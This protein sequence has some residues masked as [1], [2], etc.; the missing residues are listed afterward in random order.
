M[1]K[2]FLAFTIILGIFMT[3]CVEKKV[4]PVTPPV[5][6]VTNEKPVISGASD[7]VIAFGQTVD[8]TDGVTAN[9]EEDGDLT[10]S[11]TIDTGNF[12][13]AVPGSYDI[14][15]RVEDSE[16]L[17]AT[18]TITVQVNEEDGPT[19]EDMI[20]E[21]I[22]YYNEHQ[23]FSDDQLNLFLRGGVNQSV[24]SWDLDSESIAKNGLI[25]RP[26]RGEEAITLNYTG[27]FTIGDVTVEEDFTIIIN[28]FDDVVLATSKDVPFTNLTTEYNV[29]DGMLTLYF[30][31]N[32]SVPYVDVQSFFDL[33]DGFIDSEM[34]ITFTEEDDTETIFYQYY[35]EDEDETY[36]LEVII[37]ATN[38]NITTNDMGFYWAYVYSTETNYGRHI[39]YVEHADETYVEGENVVFDLNAYRMDIVQN[40]NGIFLPYYLVNQLFAGSSYYNVYYNYDGLYGIY[41]I[42]DTDSD[43]FIQMHSSSMNDTY[44]PADLVLHNYDMLAFDFD[45]FYG[46]QE[47]YSIDTYYDLLSNKQ[48]DL[49]SVRATT[50]DDGLFNFLYKVIDEPHTSFGYP[51]Y[52]SPEFDK[53]PSISKLADFGTRTNNWYGNLY[54]IDDAIG[55]K[56]GLASGTSWNAYSG[57]RPN[58]WFLDDAKTSV[59]ITLDEFNTADIVESDTYDVTEVNDVLEVSDSSLIVPSITEGTKFF[60]YNSSTDANKIL[61]VIAKGASA[62]FVDD[63]KASLVELGYT[64]VQESSDEE[65]KDNGYYALTL[66]EITYMAQVNYDAEYGVLYISFADETPETYGA[67]WLVIADVMETVKGD[68]AVYMEIVMDKLSEVAPDLENAMLDITWNTGGNVGALYRIIGFITDQPYRVSSMSMDSGSTSTSYVQIVGQPYNADLDWALLTSGVTFSAANAMATMF[69]ENDLGPIYGMTSGGGTASITPVLLPNGTAFTMSSNNLEA[70]RLGAGTE[71]DPYVYVNNELGIV[72]DVVLSIA[73]IYDAETLLAAFG[74]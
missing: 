2:L 48:D 69:S 60:F 12:D 7:F 72:P 23:F 34:N 8:F 63:Y 67:D 30:E 51:S 35:D 6:V 15:Y 61:E 56:W 31:E 19:A 4:D 70:L 42:P 3:G 58:Y 54:D 49:L 65:S 52:Y 47:Y 64:L 41:S 29:E 43:E 14:A 21:D 68:S 55:A 53:G 44:L 17:T 25:I 28:P 20:A 16:G 71:E 10:S 9:D 38:D 33:L 45:Y 11:I 74:E 13:S 22:T 37:D 50:I 40:E 27:T 18:A 36:D 73:D 1:K 59:V 39:E 57:F 66:G 32:G 62:S 5:D 46:L 26:K 24:I